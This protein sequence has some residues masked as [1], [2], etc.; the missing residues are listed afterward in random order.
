MTEI[1]LPPKIQKEIEFTIKKEYTAAHIGS[2]S[3]SVLATPSMI[4]FMEIACGT[5][6][7][8]HLP[9]GYTTVGTKVCVDHFAAVQQ[10]ETIISKSTL[11]QQDRKKLVFSV[12]VVYKDK[13]IGKG[14]HERVIVNE[15]R[16]LDKIN[17]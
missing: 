15:K 14:I 3:V 12:E 11:D 4:L 10:G 17:N 2:G 9:K 7:H 13:L 6:A 16:F 8:E 1:I 5:L